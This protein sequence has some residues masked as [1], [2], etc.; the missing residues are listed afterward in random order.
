MFEL[1]QHQNDE[2]GALEIRRQFWRLVA[3]KC[4]EQ[5]PGNFR[6]IISVLVFPIG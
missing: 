1:V 6:D 3:K 2:L 4:M 5:G